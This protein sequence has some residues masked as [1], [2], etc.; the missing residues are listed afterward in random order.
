MNPKRWE[1]IRCN[2]EIERRYGIRFVLLDRRTGLIRGADAGRTRT[3][4]LKLAQ[5]FEEAE[6]R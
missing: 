4:L 1:V 2:G 3:H 5:D 6:R